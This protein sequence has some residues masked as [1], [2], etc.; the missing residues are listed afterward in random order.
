MDGDQAR[1]LLAL[2]VAALFDSVAGE[3]G[4]GPGAAQDD[5]LADEPG[6]GT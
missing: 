3:A 4:A 6:Y 5:D 2:I 1:E